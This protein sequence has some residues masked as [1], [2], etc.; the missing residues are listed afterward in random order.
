MKDKAK[1]KTVELYFPM[2]TQV[3]PLLY[4]DPMTQWALRELDGLCDKQSGH[5]LLFQCRN[6][7]ILKTTLYDWQS[8]PDIE[9]TLYTLSYSKN[10]TQYPIALMHNNIKLIICIS[11]STS[12]SSEII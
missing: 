8:H 7:Q 11:Y 10:I 9:F 6:T 4:I 3:T 5:N 2:L 12:I 1:R